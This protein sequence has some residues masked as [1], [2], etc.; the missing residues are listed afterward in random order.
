MSFNCAGRTHIGLRR[1]LNED[2]W[3]SAPEKGLW[4]VADGMGG[5][6]AGEVASGMIV[7][8]L[9][10]MPDAGPG[11][12]ETTLRE[13]NA[14]LVRL[15]AKSYQKRTIGSTAVVLTIRDGGYRCIWVGD[16][17]AYLYRDG[18]LRQLTRDHSLVQD[19]VD[20]GMLEAAEAENHPN[21]NIVT[22]AVGAAEILKTDSVSGSVLP[23]DL[24][25]L[26]SDGLTKV[27]PIE[28]L[29]NILASG[30]LE[31]RADLLIES[32]LEG[33]AP[34]NVTLILVE[35]V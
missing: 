1:K 33:G 17:R 19:L 24:F 6:E 34:D 8:A 22:R 32:T 16:S 27:V 23:G 9:S 4:A 13:V 30:T 26:V 25:L 11:M 35:V 3:F 5:H 2:A 21:A 14:A 10:A 7:D 28:D 15:A 12:P 18:A 29:R 31:Q 20:A